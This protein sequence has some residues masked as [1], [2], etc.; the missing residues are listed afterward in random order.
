MLSYAWALH[1]NCSEEV[2]L[3]D[4]F[5]YSGSSLSIWT[6]QIWPAG[7]F[8]WDLHSEGIHQQA[9]H[10]TRHVAVVLDLASAGLH[11]GMAGRS[12]RIDSLGNFVVADY[13]IEGGPSISTRHQIQQISRGNKGL[14]E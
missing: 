6:F 3:G 10:K 14:Q 11:T 4:A 12:G 8:A 9:C 5:G 2:P 7:Y 13:L 1:R